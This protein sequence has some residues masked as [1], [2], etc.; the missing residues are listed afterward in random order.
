MEVTYYYYYDYCTDLNM[1]IMYKLILIINM[2]ISSCKTVYGMN[3]FIKYLY[4]IPIILIVFTYIIII[5]SIIRT[6]HQ[7]THQ[8]LV[9]AHPL[10][11]R[12]SK[13]S[14]SFSSLLD[15]CSAVLALV[16]SSYANIIYHHSRARFFMP[17]KSG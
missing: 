1:S 15:S 16:L 11:H 14:N 4:L 10:E 17:T 13:L 3:N 2:I 6:L 12:T 5:V 7:I 8:V 9:K